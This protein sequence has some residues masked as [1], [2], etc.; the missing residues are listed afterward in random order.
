MQNALEN[1][2]G[3]AAGLIGLLVFLALWAPKF[4]VKWRGYRAQK[5]EKKRMPRE[6]D[7]SRSLVLAPEG[8]SDIEDH[9]MHGRAIRIF[10]S[11]KRRALGVC[12]LLCLP[13]AAA[14]FCIPAGYMSIRSICLIAGLFF[15]ILGALSLRHLGDCAIFYKTGAVWRSNGKR[16]D[17]DYNAIVSVTKRKALMPGAAG[18]AVV[19]FGDGSISVLDGFYMQGGSGIG[20]IFDHLTQRCIRSRAEELKRL[21]S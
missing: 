15:A 20:E 19:H 11:S 5:A 14:Y 8:V 10:R 1:L 16:H 7:A 12:L 4:A 2:L 21:M 3:P 18:I 6:H 9:A 17:I 13:L